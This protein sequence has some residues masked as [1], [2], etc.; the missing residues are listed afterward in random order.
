VLS[1]SRAPPRAIACCSSAGLLQAG[2]EQ[3]LR[4]HVIAEL[5]DVVDHSGQ[6]GGDSIFKGGLQAGRRGAPRA[7][8]L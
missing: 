7:L 3:L 1:N 4:H 2:V 6:R 5:V 8:R